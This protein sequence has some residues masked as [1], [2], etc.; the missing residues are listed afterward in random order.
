[1]VSP[2]RAGA[3]KFGFSV[4][5]WTWNT[6]AN[7]AYLNNTYIGVG[8]QF[9]FVTPKNLTVTQSRTPL[10][11][12]IAAYFDQTELQVDMEL[13][14]LLNGIPTVTIVDQVEVPLSLPEGTSLLAL[15]T[16]FPFCQPTST[17][18][19]VL[20]K[21]D[22]IYYDP[23]ISVLF[24]DLEAP[25]PLSPQERKNKHVV[26][27][28]VPVVIVVVLIVAGTIVL[29]AVF[30]PSVRDVF[31]PYNQKKVLKAR[32]NTDL[33]TRDGWKHSTNPTK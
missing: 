8:L 28:V 15:D 22:N 18:N 10:D 3:V 9:G 4:N 21:W 23:S 13:G 30:V 7:Q 6:T 20:T 5:G 17:V 32:D 12:F 2:C 27:I 24:G 25:A 31:T 14:Y 29:L 19:D 26:A 11:Y 33:N 16:P 1:M